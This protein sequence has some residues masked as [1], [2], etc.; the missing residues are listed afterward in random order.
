MH[1]DFDIHST[2][3]SGV[4][5]HIMPPL[6][7]PVPSRHLPLPIIPIIDELEPVVECTP[8]RISPSK[9]HADV[10]ESIV[11]TNITKATLNAEMNRRMSLDFSEGE[12]N[13]AGSVTPELR[14]RVNSITF[15]DESEIEFDAVLSPRLVKRTVRRSKE[16]DGNRSGRPSSK[17]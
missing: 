8:Q 5:F 4:I 16:F 17:S 14:P 1:S 10:H 3:C 11:D 6:S 15:G 13:G 2:W 9:V 12:Q 7:L